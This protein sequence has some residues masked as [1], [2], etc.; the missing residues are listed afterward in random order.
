LPVGALFAVGEKTQDALARWGISSVAELADADVSTVQHAVGRVAGAHLVD[1]AW[2]RDPRPVHPGRQERSV[3]AEATFATDVADLAV[4]EEKAHELADR[5]AA[6]LRTNGLVT[7]TITVKI[8][9]GD[10]RTLTR[11]RT[12][13]T[14]TDV[15]RELFLAARELVA[16]V[17]LRGLPVH[18]V[19][20][21]AE[22]LSPAAT[23]IRLPTPDEASD[24]P[25]RSRWEAE[26]ATDQL[27]GRSGR[28]PIPAGAS[29]SGGVSSGSTT[30]IVPAD[31]S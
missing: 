14:P 29:Q 4:V 15:G 30:T 5:C 26:R 27:R 11:S 9:T 31:L 1:L 17:D 22:G 2:G 19:G 18:L 16:G 12:L 23:S 3:A 25:E 10:H 13:A 7:R 24:A 6:R 21:V 20:V 28:G 8:R